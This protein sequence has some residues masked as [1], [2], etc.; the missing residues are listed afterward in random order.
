[1]WT[2]QTI[3]IS[4]T[5]SRLFT[6]VPTG[7]ILL[8]L[9]AS[10]Q[11]KNKTDSELLNK[12]LEYH[13]PEDNWPKLKTRLYLSSADTAGKEHHFEIELDNTTG[14][15]AHIS[16]P[17]GKEVVKGISGKGKEFFLLDGKEEISEE[18]RQ[19]Y[20][21]TTEALNWVHSFYGYLYGLPMKLT[22]EGV[23][24]ND[25][26]NTEELD[27]ETYKVLQVNYD[28]SVGS[29][30]WFFYLHPETHAMKAYR[31]NH[32]DPK[33]GEYILLEQELLVDGIKIPKIRKW[34]WNNTNKYIGTDTLIKA[35]PLSSH[36]I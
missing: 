29:D 33:S 6:A 35:E 1:M 8:L 3:L 15:F 7:F 10:C 21:L 4:F 18:E 25:A 22:D 27:G 30:N 17:D 28:P 12:T 20:E 11:P 26:E 34:Y 36:K 14:Y 32:G 23:N 19:K 31:F 13:D 9:L 5:T 2:Y 24:V 16:H